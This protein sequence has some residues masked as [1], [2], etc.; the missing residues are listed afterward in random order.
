[1]LEPQCL[2]L[3]NRNSNSHAYNLIQGDSRH[4]PECSLFIADL[5]HFPGTPSSP[6]QGNHRRFSRTH[7]GHITEP[8]ALISRLLRSCASLTEICLPPCFPALLLQLLML[9]SG[10][11]SNVPQMSYGSGRGDD[12]RSMDFLVKARERAQ[13]HPNKATAR[14]GRRGQPLI[15]PAFGLAAG[16]APSKPEPEP[17]PGLTALI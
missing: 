9:E 10:P 15:R 12:D 4:H 3:F 14:P 6:I 11:S 1:M 7:L 5:L 8:A 17:G 2:H 13:G 16:T